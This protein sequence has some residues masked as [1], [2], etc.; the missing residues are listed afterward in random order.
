METIYNE[1]DIVA[2]VREI[3]L[4]WL[5]HL[6]TMKEESIPKYFMKENWTVDNCKDNS[7]GDGEQELMIRKKGKK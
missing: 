5:G 6:C 7:G 2:I 1:P 3:R 4:A